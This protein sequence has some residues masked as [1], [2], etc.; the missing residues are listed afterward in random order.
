MLTLGQA[1]LATGL[2]KPTIQRAIKS[3]KLS[4]TKKEDGSYD[5]DPAELHRV[6]PPVTDTITSSVKQ[7]DTPLINSALQQGFN[8]LHELVDNL[9]DERD[10]L[11]KRLDR[12]E[13]ARAKDAEELRRLTLLI[14][15]Q[16]EPKQETPV[17]HKPE[18]R[19]FNKLFGRR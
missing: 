9:K 11:R 19:L 3:G 7:S 5:I 8:A 16:I 17:E 2:S 6:F 13:A 15:H 14:T 4:A 12:S 1:A 10:D 18:S